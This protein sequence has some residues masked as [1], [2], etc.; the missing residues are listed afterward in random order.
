MVGLWML[1]E[2]ESAS[3]WDPGAALKLSADDESPG[4]EGCVDSS[5]AKEDSELVESMLALLLAVGGD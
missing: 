3:D 1:V 2:S 5:V 4:K